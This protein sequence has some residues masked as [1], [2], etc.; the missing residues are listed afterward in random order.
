VTLPSVSRPTIVVGRSA[1]TVR[2]SVGVTGELGWAQAWTGA[3]YGPDGFYR[4][5]AGP[6]AHFRTA[7]HAAAPVVA[8]ALAELAARHGCRAVVDLGAGRGELATALAAFA[9]ELAV[10]AVD[11]VGRPDGLPDAI[12]WTRADPAAGDRLPPWPDRFTD[13]VL[14]V[15]WELLDVIPCPVLEVDDDGR[16]RA[17]LV[18][19]RTGAERLG[20]PASEVLDRAEREW[21]ARW[22]PL[23]SG[24]EPGTR[25]EVG[26]A[27]DRL[28]AGVAGRLRSGLLLAVDYAHTAGNRPP[29]GSL[30]A[31]RSGRQV[32]PRPDG[33]CDLTAEVALDAVE[34]AAR[35]AGAGA[36]RAVRQAE[37][38][39]DLL[40][41]PLLADPPDGVLDQVPAEL[42]DPGGLGGFSWLLQPVP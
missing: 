8:A 30:S 12:G 28:W 1:A 15:G 16:L 18:D 17:V 19:P 2:Q 32:P 5:P 13:Q 38:L 41:G 36:G 25:V 37:A 42:L 6:A 3:L 29:G 31:F 4:Q 9:P 21:C 24:A 7:V 39:R 33:S 40:A 11:V 26:L 23:P 20:G 27:R 34:A 22:W 35:A 14:V 10:H